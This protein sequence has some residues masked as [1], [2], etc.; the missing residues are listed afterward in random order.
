MTQYLVMY[1]PKDQNEWFPSL[2]VWPEIL[3]ML[4]KSDEVGGKFRIYRIG[5]F[6]P[7]RLWIMRVNGMFWLEDMYGNYIER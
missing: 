5:S 4:R 3:S 1:Q 2:H 6:D 7:Q